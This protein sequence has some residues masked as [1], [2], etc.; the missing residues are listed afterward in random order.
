MVKETNNEA[1][2]CI[3]YDSEKAKKLKAS[4]CVKRAADYSND[5]LAESRKVS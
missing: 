2:T 1:D 4:D 5:T 3:S